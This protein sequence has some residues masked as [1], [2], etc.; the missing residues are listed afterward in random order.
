[1][2]QMKEKE[3][4][5]FRVLLVEWYNAPKCAEILWYHKTTLYRLLQVHNI[6]YK[7][8]RY[9]YIWWKWWGRVLRDIWKKKD[10]I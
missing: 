5:V 4:E 3:L 2:K 9:Q 7:D 10:S 1:M 8:R 6:S